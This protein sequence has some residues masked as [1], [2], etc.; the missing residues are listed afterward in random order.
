MRRPH[1]GNTAFHAGRLSRSGD[2]GDTA[3]NLVRTIGEWCPPTC[4]TSRVSPYFN[5]NAGGILPCL[6]AGG[7]SGRAVPVGSTACLARSADVNR[8]CEARGTVVNPAV[9][10]VRESPAPGQRTSCSIPCGQSVDGVPRYL[11]RICG[12]D[13]M[14]RLRKTHRPPHQRPRLAPES[15][16][17]RQ[18]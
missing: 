11:S 14:P 6:P 7:E 8:H 17:V 15:G 1:Q 13:G 4:K 2:A 10:A 18:R 12:G 3:L 16:V 5:L 9:G